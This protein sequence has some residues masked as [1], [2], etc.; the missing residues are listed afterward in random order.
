[1]NVK[2]WNK[3]IINFCPGIGQ[4]RKISFLNI[5]KKIKDDYRNEKKILFKKN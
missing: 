3:E 2:T 4:G 5:Y 1:M